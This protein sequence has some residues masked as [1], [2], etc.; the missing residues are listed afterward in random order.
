MPLFSLIKEDL[1]S[2]GLWK[3]TESEEEL[4]ARLTAPLPYDTELRAY[5][6]PKRRMEYL[7]IRVLLKEML[8]QQ[9]YHISYTPFG[10]PYFKDMDMHISISHSGEYAAVALHRKSPVGVDIE[11]PSEKIIRLSSRFVSQTEI[12]QRAAMTEDELRW[13]Y[14]LHWSGKESVYKVLHREGVDFLA[15]LQIAPFR[16]QEESFSLRDGFQDKN[17]TVHFRLFADFVC[18]WCISEP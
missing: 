15:H 5:A 8:G 9:E 2:V 17:Y 14:L 3:T 11:K 1:L 6:H 10:Q 12:P 7:A 18:T 13:Q 16:L 4:R